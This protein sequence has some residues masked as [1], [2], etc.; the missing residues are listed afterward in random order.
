MITW[1][2]KHKK[3]LIVTI[4]IS[5][6]AF[7]GA[8]FVG[9]GSYDYGN[10]DGSVAL[11]G[12]R[13]VSVEEYQR[14]YSSLYDNYSRIFGQQFNQE[15][16][17]N[18]N[19]RDLALQR[20]IQKNLFLSYGDYLGF[21]VS[22][23]EV[24]KELVKIDAFILN[25][26]FD[27]KTYIRVLN[28]NRTNPQTFEESIKRNILLEKVLNVFQIKANK[29]ELKLLNTLLFAKDDISVSIFNINDIDFIANEKDLKKYWEKNKN[30]YMSLDAYTYDFDTIVL[31]KKDFTKE[32]ILK[33]YKKY[34]NDFRKSDGKVK[35]IDEAK[36]D[37]ILALSKKATKKLALKK[38]LKLKKN[39]EKFVKKETLFANELRFSKENNTKI[40]N[41]KLGSVLKPFFDNNAYTTIK[42][43][44]KIKPKTLSFSKALIQIRIDY[45]QEIKMNRLNKL[46]KEEL[47]NFKG[48]NI[49][50]VSQ[51]STQ[52]LEGLNQTETSEF[53]K[54]LFSS[55][56]KKGRISLAN[57]IIVYKINSSKLATFDKT[58]EKEV[59]SR[60][61][62]LLQEELMSNLVKTLENT[63]DVKT[64][65]NN[66]S[67]N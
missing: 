7:V 38:Y 65:L 52:K 36:D 46:A 41:A 37:V 49:G 62:N 66:R 28:Q 35:N 12:D 6:I 43:L 64:L 2:Q 4:W 23:E 33:Y 5:T 53:L 51:S 16:A 11:V 26:K 20:T 50:Y 14:E 57:K 40:I 54:Q 45:E 31:V 25:G 30:N 13:E 32:E 44:E 27:K 15:M 1:M 56:I 8:G 48:K 17:D 21:N 24:A 67:N 18:L 39:E 42:V 29:N 58:K 19:L 59:Q 22:N 3:W 55:N 47:K 9:W 61:N 34:K 63:Y 60:L 10:S